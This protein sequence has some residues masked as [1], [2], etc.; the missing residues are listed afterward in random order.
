MVVYG[1]LYFDLD[2][3]LNCLTMPR[4]SELK[5]TIQYRA[6]ATVYWTFFTLSHAHDKLNYQNYC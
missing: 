4:G 1:F 2:K 6:Q 3:F 5:Q